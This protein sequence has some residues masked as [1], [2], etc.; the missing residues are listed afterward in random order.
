[1]FENCFEDYNIFA[2]IT[3]T[4]LQIAVFIRK[5]LFKRKIL[6]NVLAEEY[7]IKVLLFECEPMCALL[8]FTT[9]KQWFYP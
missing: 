6:H 8:L 2:K 3:K 7:S 9:T 5:V 1:M 4:C